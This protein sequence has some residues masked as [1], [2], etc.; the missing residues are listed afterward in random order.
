M[1]IHICIYITYVYIYVYVYIYIMDLLLM[2]DIWWFVNIATFQRSQKQ[3]RPGTA[4]IPISLA[5]KQMGPR[6]FHGLLGS[7][8]GYPVNPLLVV[9]LYDPNLR[10]VYVFFFQKSKKRPLQCWIRT[11]ERGHL[12]AHPTVFFHNRSGETRWLHWTS[13]ENHQLKPWYLKYNH[14]LYSY[15]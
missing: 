10:F 15:L 3:H 14:K 11:C 13:T 8:I 4:K 5:S 6:K 12:S 9:G 1:Y 2:T 7:F